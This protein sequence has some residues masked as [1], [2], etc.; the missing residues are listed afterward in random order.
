M[1]KDMLLPVMMVG[2]TLTPRGSSMAL[3]AIICAAMAPALAMPMG[4]NYTGH[5]DN[6]TSHP[7]GPNEVEIQQ[8]ASGMNT[9]PGTPLDGAKVQWVET[10][11]LKNG[12][13]PVH[14]TITFTTPSG[15]TSSAYKGTAT[16][17]PQ[18]R[19]TARGTYQVTNSTG[20]LAGVKGNGNFSVAYTSKADFTGEWRGEVQMPG[21]N[22][23]K[24]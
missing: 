7:R 15:A 23:S 14:G 4:G 1:S 6:Q 21:Q 17:D 8:T 11:T 19:V 18:G 22:S 2:R 9:G 24:R 16:T 13:G 20:E 10:V 3:A 5:V 12:Q